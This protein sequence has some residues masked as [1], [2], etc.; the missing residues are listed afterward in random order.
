VRRT[1]I[2][3][4]LAAAGLAL[5]GCGGHA[6]DPYDKEVAA[7]KNTAEYQQT[8]EKAY[9]VMVLMINETGETAEDCEFGVWS[10]FNPDDHPLRHGAWDDGCQA[11][12]RAWGR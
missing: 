9:R 4:T 1:T 6:A 8:Y 5:A 3:A 10:E 12:D 2:T 11:A 7:Y